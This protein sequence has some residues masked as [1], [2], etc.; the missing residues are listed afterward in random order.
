[1]DPAAFE[2]AVHD[3]DPL[4]TMVVV[5]SKSWSTAETMVNAAMVRAWVLV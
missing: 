4:T 2:K 5:V 1:M 3:T